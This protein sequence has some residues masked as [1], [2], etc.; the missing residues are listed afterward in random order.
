MA[1]VIEFLRHLLSDTADQ[2]AYRADP[3]GY[4]TAHGF[5]DLAGEDVVEAMP[6]VR[7]RLD[8][9]IAAELPTS[10]P[11]ASPGPDETELDAALRQID[12]LL[13]GPEPLAD[14]PADVAVEADEGEH[15]EAADH[16][17]QHE[18]EHEHHEPEHHDEH[19]QAHREPEHDEGEHQAQERRDQGHEHEGPQGE[20][21]GIS[22]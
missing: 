16:E 13:A 14:E 5:D 3:G 15:D 8:E 4:L 11:P 10:L 19:E 12:H 18:D 21:F 22:W 20:D 1:N 7:P 17:H 9:S 2:A 6:L